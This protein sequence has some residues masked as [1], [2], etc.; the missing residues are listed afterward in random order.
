[1]NFEMFAQYGILG[2]LLCAIGYGIWE[3]GKWLAP[4]LDLIVET[5]LKFVENTNIALNRLADRFEVF[6]GRLDTL[7]EI[8][9][10]QTDILSRLSDT[11]KDKDRE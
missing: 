8:Q 5:H 11:L 10:S 2:L 1:M 7:E 6:D 4:K 3:I 9:K